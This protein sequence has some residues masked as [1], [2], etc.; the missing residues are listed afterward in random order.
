MQPQS[1]RTEL[2]RFWQK[3][4]KNNPVT[5]AVSH[6]DFQQTSALSGL[7][8]SHHSFP[9]LKDTKFRSL[10][11]SYGKIGKPLGEGA[12]GN[13]RLI[14]SRESSQVLYAVKEFRHREEVE[15]I[16]DYTKKLN[17]EYCIGLALK[18]PNIIETI[19][20]IH[21]AADHVY[22]VMEYCEYDLFAI[23][24]SG[25]MSKAEIY[26]DFKQIMNGVKYMLDSGL[27][28]RD[29]KLD[30]CVINAQGIV[31]I[32]DFG[33][34]VVYRYPETEKINYATGIVGSDPYLAPEVVSHMKYDP[35]PSD[36]WSAAMIFCCMLMRKFPWKSPRLSDP[37]FRQFVES[38]KDDKPASAF[39]LSN[40][41][42]MC[43]PTEVQSL[44]KGMLILDPAKRYTIEQC[45]ED[46]W[47]SSIHFCTL[48]YEYDDGSSS[49]LSDYN[50]SEPVNGKRRK[51]TSKTLVPVAGHSH[52]N[53][54]FDDAH[55][56]SLEKKKTKKK[57][58]EGKN[59]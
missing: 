54:E 38:F 46:P 47:L 55:I 28:H 56:A 12:G 8:L 6:E 49:S 10:A 9:G 42:L 45:W 15:S 20:I 58:K 34:A 57:L 21:E 44:V 59:H 40:R 48:H 18:H 27:A 33:S 53:V 26:C 16:R 41:L 39:S 24:M 31:K 29:L 22:Q 51:I 1:S 50:A 30:N 43:L 23:V 19:E 7:F 2:K 32:I 25:K 37:S 4:W 35:R 13:V 5:P 17:A 3:P 52:T 11:K 14:T 36:I